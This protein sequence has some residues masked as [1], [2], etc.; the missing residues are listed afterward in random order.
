[1]SDDISDT[2]ISLLC[3]IGQANRY[4]H[5]NGDNPDIEHLA[6]RGYITIVSDNAGSTLQLTEK[7]SSFLSARG[8]TL[9]EA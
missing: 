8:A 3:D 1:M 2:Q 9:N 7:A 5:S 6:N 4:D